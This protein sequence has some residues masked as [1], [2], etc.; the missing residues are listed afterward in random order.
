MANNLSIGLSS[1]MRRFYIDGYQPRK[2]EKY[3]EVYEE[4][5]SELVL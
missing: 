2:G 3:V 5:V 4:I 1:L